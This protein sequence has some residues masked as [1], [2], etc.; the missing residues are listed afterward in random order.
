M[1]N[2]IY[3]FCFQS[4]LPFCKVRN[5]HTLDSS[6]YNQDETIE[7]QNK[8]LN[9]K[10]HQCYISV[11]NLNTQSLPSSFDKFSYMMNKYNFDIVALSETW[12]KN[13]KTQLEYV[14]I[15]GYKSEFKN[16][17]SKSGGGVG[18]YIKKHMNFNVRH[19]L[20]KT[21]ES[22]EILWTE[23]QGGNKNTPDLS[24]TFKVLSSP[25]L[26]FI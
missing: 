26:S 16:R 8:H 9:A 22:I 6:V 12:L 10:K 11:A 25:V 5:L 20:R 23:V 21:D 18:F 2:W 13:N 4:V 15:D 14:Q 17:E 19:D 24:S 7:Y 1:Q 3:S